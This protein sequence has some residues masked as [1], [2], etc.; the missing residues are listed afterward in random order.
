MKLLIDSCY[1]TFTDKCDPVWAMTDE[2]TATVSFEQ[3]YPAKNKTKPFVGDNVIRGL[4]SAMLE[5]GPGLTLGK[6]SK[7]GYALLGRDQPDG[8]QAPVGRL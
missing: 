5:D 7:I 8:T 3:I 2:D 6:K 1:S 4:F